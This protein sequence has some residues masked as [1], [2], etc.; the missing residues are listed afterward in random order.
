MVD[1]ADA[2]ERRDTI[3]IAGPSLSEVTTGEVCTVNAEILNTKKLK[4]EV[5]T[6]LTKIIHFVSDA[7]LTARD[8]N[9]AKSK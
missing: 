2:Y 6:P 7:R 4:V 1:D 5:Y 9:G 8:H 3:I